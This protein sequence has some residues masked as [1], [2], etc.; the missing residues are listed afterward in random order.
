MSKSWTNLNYLLHEASTKF[1]SKYS[2]TQQVSWKNFT[3]TLKVRHPAQLPTNRMKNCPLG[4]PQSGAVR[5]KKNIFFTLNSNIS[6]CL[7]DKSKIFCYEKKDLKYKRHYKN[8]YVENCLP[9][10]TETSIR[11]WFWRFFCFFSK[12]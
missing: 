5:L 4:G 8:I 3:S 7:K 9:P 12:N 2:L 6:W 11:P 10:I 1:W